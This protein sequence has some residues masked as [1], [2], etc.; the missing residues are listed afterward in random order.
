MSVNQKPITILR[1]RARRGEDS[2]DAR[3]NH[4]LSS[5]RRKGLSD[6][7]R[8]HLDTATVVASTVPS[9]WA[10]RTELAVDSQRYNA[11]PFSDGGSVQMRRDRLPDV[12]I[13][14]RTRPLGSSPSKV[15][16]R[17]HS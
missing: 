1:K 14:G 3:G 16:M 13:L 6:G 2:R 7:D 15:P 8:V 17:C 5:R 12:P 10:R 4:R 11:H 9:R